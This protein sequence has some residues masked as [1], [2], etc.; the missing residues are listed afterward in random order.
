[1]GRTARIARNINTAPN[2]CTAL[3]CDVTVLL[4]NC[5]NATQQVMLPQA[6]KSREEWVLTGK[7]GNVSAKAIELNGAV[8]A[9]DSKGN[10]PALEGVTRPNHAQ[11]FSLP[12]Q[13]LAFVVLSGAKA[14]A[15]S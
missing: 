10:P 6:A 4:L 5:G 1:M 13:S 14:K 7:G 2:L 11:P 15:C 9:T 3:R 12:P 8:L